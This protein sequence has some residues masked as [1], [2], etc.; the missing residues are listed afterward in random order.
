[1]SWAGRIAVL[2][3]FAVQS[4]IIEHVYYGHPPKEFFEK[5]PKHYHKRSRAPVFKGHECDIMDLW[6][7]KGIDPRTLDE[8]HH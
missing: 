3:W 4:S 5:W 2:T 8:D 6:C 1:M 7:W